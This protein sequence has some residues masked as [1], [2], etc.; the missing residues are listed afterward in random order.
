MNEDSCSCNYF[1]SHKHCKHSIASKVEKKLIEIP[2]KKALANIYQERPL[3]RPP[4]VGGVL[5]LE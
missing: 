5:S 1:L 4:D 3:G 2:D